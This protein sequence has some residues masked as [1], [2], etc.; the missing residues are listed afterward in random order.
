MPTPV[1]P[2]SGLGGNVKYGGATVVNIKSWEIS[3]S[4]NMNDVS[5]F[6]NKDQ[7]VVPGLRSATATIT[8]EVTTNAAE[9]TIMKLL[10]STV[11][12]QTAAVVDLI[13][14]TVAGKKAKWTGSA[15]VNSDGSGDSVEGIV[16][17]NASLTFSGGARYS[18]T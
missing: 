12:S 16:S 11:A 17:Y 3:R 7:V 6:G 10:N 4:Q 1:T 15:F 5:A 9:R 14:S 8:G 13:I 2:L 18:T